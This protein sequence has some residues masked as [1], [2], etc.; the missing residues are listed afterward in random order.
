[1]KDLNL[2]FGDCITFLKRIPNDFVDLIFTDIPYGINFKSH[3]QNYDTRSGK[4]IKV[5]R[6]EY[7]Q[8]INNDDKIPDVKWLQE[9]FRILKEGTAI[10]ICVHWETF[11]ELKSQVI[12]CGFKPKNMIV[13]NKSNH[14]MGDLN[15]Q[16][17]PKHELILFA[18]KGRH[19]LN[20]P[21]KRMNDV[22]DVPVKFTGAK[23]F[24][25]NEKPLSWINP[26][27][28][29]SSRENEIVLDPFMGSGS[30]GESSLKLKRKF[31][32]IDNDKKYF[33]V[34]KNRLSILTIS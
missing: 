11:G 17:A 15:G 34:A 26:A 7:F 20:F 25:P 2:F 27:I 1:M 6:K 3:K 19:L 22:W 30:T 29:C 28:L 31:I 33:D 5:N 4:T 21:E 18:V 24:H 9:S 14:G 10:Y 12:E 16:F 23:R 32:G 8:E 13:L